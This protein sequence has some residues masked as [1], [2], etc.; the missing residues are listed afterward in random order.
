MASLF[1]VASVSSLG[2]PNQKRGPFHG[3]F[4][5]AACLR[6]ILLSARPRFAIKMNRTR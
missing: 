2:L 6:T 1:L 5:S 3:D 4:N